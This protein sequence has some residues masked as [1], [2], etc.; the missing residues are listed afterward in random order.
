MNPKDELA[1]EVA[2]TIQS[3]GYEVLILKPGEHPWPEA[4]EHGESMARRGEGDD[5][6]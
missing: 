4:P 6:E 5:S 3:A 2:S 1:Q